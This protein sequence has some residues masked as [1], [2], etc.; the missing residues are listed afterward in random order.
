MTR[1]HNDPGETVRELD[2]ES[3]IDLHEIFRTYYKPDG[4]ILVEALRNVSLTINRSEYV[5]IMG[6]S[7]S[8]KS[9]MMN[10]IGALDRPTSGACL[11]SGT[12]I[13]TM[14]DEELS[15]IRGRRI[16][17]VFQAFNLISQLTVTENVEVPLFY[18]DIP[19]LDR[20][21]RANQILHR[22]GLGDRLCHRPKE[23]SGGQ[24]Q[25]VAIARALVTKPDL[26]LADEPTG[27]LDSKTGLTILKLLDELH[28]DGLTIMMV[29]HDEQIADRCDRVIRLVDGEVNSDELTQKAQARLGR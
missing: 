14:S 15:S 18:Q 5:A 1:A 21:Q 9:T 6:A 3:V 4:S 8:G 29:T 20:L 27:N 16:G 22:V 10:I 12:D 26:L 28:A 7:G 11:I 25:R 24:Q 13:A 23:L 17:F 19:R 2:R